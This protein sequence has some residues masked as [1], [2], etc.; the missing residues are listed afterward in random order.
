MTTPSR[1]YIAAVA[2]SLLSACAGADSA[3]PMKVVGHVRS[4]ALPERQLVAKL[5]DSVPTLS[6]PQSIAR[7]GDQFAIADAAADRVAILSADLEPRPSFS[8][9]GSGPGEVQLPMYALAYGSTVAIGDL[10]NQRITLFDSSGK[11]IWS[12][13]TAASVR[14]FAMGP[15][16]SIYMVVRDRDHYL[17]RILPGGHTLPIARRA[18]RLYGKQD[19]DANQQP[20]GI[21]ADLVVRTADGSVHVFDNRIGVL[22]R[23]DSTGVERDARALPKSIE[24]ELK[25]ER[26]ERVASIR[27][28]GREVVTAPIVKGMTQT[29]EGMLFLLFSAKESYGLLV[30]PRTYDARILELPAAESARPLWGATAASMSGQKVT[31]VSQVG[32]FT[33]S[34]GGSE[35]ASR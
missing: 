18:M 12:Q 32:A 23:F 17:N 16:T 35:V 2:L 29:A 7:V 14:H 19:R 21:G 24:K 27:A 26:D 28:Q 5:S 20:V 1:P 10:T 11:A 8:R 34:L 33:Y 30:D 4:D 22:L 13:R 25:G 9:S 3:A 15:D 6:S 31:V